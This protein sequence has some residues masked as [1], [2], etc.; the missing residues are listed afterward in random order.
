MERSPREVVDIQRSPPPS[1]RRVYPD[2]QE[3][4]QSWRLAWMK[5]ELLTRLRDKKK[6]IQEEEAGTG[7]LEGIQKCCPGLQRWV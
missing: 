3:D 4:K 2:N 1:S 6:A 5:K 7:H